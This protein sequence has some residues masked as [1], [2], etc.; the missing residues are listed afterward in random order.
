[1]LRYKIET[2]PGVVALHD[3]WPRNGTGLFLQP[4]SPHGGTGH[5]QHPLDPHTQKNLC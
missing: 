3:I 5:G 4:R 2:R 1:M